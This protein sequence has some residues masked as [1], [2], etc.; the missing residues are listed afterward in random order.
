MSAPSLVLLRLIYSALAS[1]I[2]GVT[3]GFDVHQPNDKYYKMVKRM[4]DVAD[5]ITM[6]G[7]FL[8][9]SFPILGYLPAWFPGGGFKTWAADAKRDILHISGS[10]FNG[11]KH[12]VVSYVSPWI[13]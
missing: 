11:A 5:T 13:L 2:L 12:E 7:N 9:E 1:T 4:S 8:V 10:L 3:Y 6:P